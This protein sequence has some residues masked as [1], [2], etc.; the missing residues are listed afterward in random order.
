MSRNKQE[1]LKAK[2]S[3][4]GQ[5]SRSLTIRSNSGNFT[6]DQ[7]ALL[8]QIGLFSGLNQKELNSLEKGQEVWFNRGDKIFAEGQHDTF[9][10]VVE[11]K[12]DVILRDGVKESVLTT[13]EAGDHFGE[14]PI[15]LEWSDHRCAAF[16]AE[17][18][19][20]I[21][22]NKDEFWRMVYTSPSLIKQ[23]LHS[24]AQL[25][26]KLETLLQHNQNL[27]A[28]GGLAAGLAHELNNPAAAANRSIT[29][30]S[31]SIQEWRSVVRMLNGERGITPAQWS[32]ISKLRDSL[33]NPD[34]PSGQTLDIAS[35]STSTDT[36]RDDP[37]KQSEK[38]EEII[39]WLGNHGIR[40][41]WGM[42][43]DLATAGI[44]VTD[45]NEIAR[46][47]NSTQPIK[48]NQQQHEMT[49]NDMM[50]K[51][52]GNILSWLTVTRRVDQLLYEIKSSTARI[53]DLVSAVKSYSYMD[54]APLQ[55]VDIHKGIESTLTILQ[56][57]LR[58]AGITISREYDPNLPR[59]KAF[60]SELNQV[61][62]NL[63]DNAIDAIGE[64]GTISI[65]TKN[66]GNDHI[67]VEIADNGSQGIPEG[68]KSRIFDPFFTTKDLGKGTGLGLSISHRI[69]TETHRGDIRVH[70]RPGET[71]FQVRLPINYNAEGLDQRNRSWI[72]PS[73]NQE[74]S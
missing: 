43:S 16:A 27:I 7:E 68:L 22:W 58:K 74:T 41:G 34:P 15:I 32:Y 30:L 20:L 46:A 51:N 53:S 3:D 67:L 10:V 65:R 4:E 26:K 31:E 28:L 54:Q 60:G 59:L 37:L 73:D 52:I 55:D 5:S 40:N 18:S 45:L 39:D 38:E 9:Y 36:G 50:D 71:R 47:I 44:N 29:Q 2:F 56:Y 62:A 70:S 13:Y 33:Q 49:Y 61:W 66:E 24:M 11:G 21:K 23:I 42:A 19:R 12:V 1:T 63:I 35:A 14:L 48:A 25:L 64:H 6:H 17:K 57:K 69:V 72:R 8:H